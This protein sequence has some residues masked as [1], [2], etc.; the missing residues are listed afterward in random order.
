MKLWGRRDAVALVTSDFEKYV[1]KFWEDVEESFNE[2]KTVQVLRPGGMT[3]CDIQN[4]RI[5]VYL[6]SAGVIRKI[7]RG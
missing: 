1:G 4:D 6:T 7:I 2:F 3:T 5:R